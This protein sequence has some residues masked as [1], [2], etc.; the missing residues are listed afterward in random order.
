MSANADPLELTRLKIV[1]ATIVINIIVVALLALA[2]WSDWKTGLALNLFD[3]VLLLFFVWRRR[4]DFLG[5]L[6]V[7]GLA[8]GLSELAADAWLVD[9]TRTLDYSIG[10]GPMLWRSPIWMP[11]AWE[12]VAVQFSCL[13]LW[14][15]SRFGN[16]TGLVGIGILGAVNI[17]YYEEMAKRIHWWQYGGCRMISNTPYYIIAGELLIAVAFTLLA[18]LLPRAS[19][20]RTAAIGLAGGV[21][22]FI[23]YAVAYGVTDGFARH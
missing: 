17:P 12:I 21:A 3:N 15:C 9:W 16:A 18:K 7:F 14:F 8:A 19:W 10:G 13:G 20:S 6:M 23:A 2:Q 1:G 4:D 22:I 5:R 11:P